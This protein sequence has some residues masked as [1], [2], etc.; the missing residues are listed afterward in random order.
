LWQQ[1]RE[2]APLTGEDWFLTGFGFAAL[3]WSVAEI[4]FVLRIWNLRAH[5]VVLEIW[6]SGNPVART[7]LVVVI[8]LVVL[9]LAL[10][11]WSLVH[12]AWHEANTALRWLLR[13]AE[14]RLHQEAIAALRAVPVW[15]DLPQARILA[16]SRDLHLEAIAE[17]EEVVRQG[18]TE[19]RF[20]I[21]SSGAFEAVVDGQVSGRLV[22]GDYFGEAALLSGAPVPATVVAVEPS[23]LFW[24]DRANFRAHLAHDVDVRDRLLAAQAYRAEVAGMPLFR[25]LGPTDLDL[26]LERFEP[27]TV[28]AGGVLMRQGEPGDRFYV[29]RSGELKVLKDGQELARLGAGDAVGEIALLLDR[30]RTATVEAVSRA[31]LLALDSQAF[32]DLLTRYCHKATKLE[33]L[34][35]HRLVAHRRS[36][37]HVSG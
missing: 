7:L 15:A 13:R 30:P 19:D 4:F 26:L 14:G 9:P 28:D 20:Y 2:R 10:G 35:H 23:H 24:V 37:Q 34:S 17:G 16:L 22:R 1:L 8:C 29:I 11:L 27:H 36:N 31:E 33:R 18:D 3:L 12:A 5:T 32:K 21:V 25:R 6:A